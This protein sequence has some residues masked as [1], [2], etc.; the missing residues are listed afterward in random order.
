M[1][2]VLLAVV[3]VLLA[4]VLSA[5]GSSHRRAS[6]GI[7]ASVEVARFPAQT[8]NFSV[9][10]VETAFASQGIKLQRDPLWE[11]G[12]KF[13]NLD[14]GHYGQL[15]HYVSVIVSTGTSP[16]R[17]GVALMVRGHTVRR[18]RQGNVAAFSDSDTFTAVKSAL[19]SL[20]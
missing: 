20:H 10:Q 13:I 11:K 15:P 14:Y 16:A 4:V 17:S 6:Q 7:T 1:K 2:V 8:H 5:C 3:A 18:A 12:G 9:R 19:A